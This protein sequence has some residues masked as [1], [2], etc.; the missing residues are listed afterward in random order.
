MV[1]ENCTPIPNVI[2]DRLIELQ[3]C[4]IT[5][6]FL[7]LTKTTAIGSTRAEVSFTDI[8][9]ETGLARAS[10]SKAL[11]GL[12]DKGWLTRHKSQSGYAY[13]ISNDFLSGNQ[14]GSHER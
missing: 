3:H 10:V 1:P 7:V 4:E 14:R 2:L 12:R 9:K 11:K 8:Q 5:V 13:A 6:V